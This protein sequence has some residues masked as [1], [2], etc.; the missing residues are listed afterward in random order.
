MKSQI[1]INKVK[2]SFPVFHH[3]SKS[4]RAKIFE[5]GKTKIDENSYTVFNTLNVNIKRGEK[6]GLIGSNGAGKST[7]LKL[8]AG[9]YKPDSGTVDVKGTITSIF[10][11]KTGLDFEATGYENIPLLMVANYIPLSKK[12]EVLQHVETFTELG[13]ALSRPVRTY[14]AGM[15][16]RLTF[17]IA[18]AYV[19][20]II[21]IDEVIGVGDAK[22]K[23]KSK[24]HIEQIMRQSGTLVLASHSNNILKSFCSRGIVL[25][26]GEIVFDGHIDDAVLFMK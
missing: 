15:R 3:N 11:L 26:A 7:F 21:L 6:V 14:S 4:L 18:T 23:K 12:P 17:A 19:S 2:L 25:E 1:V 5:I 9:V 8:L 22:F 10:D 13:E 24:E 20:E 16:L